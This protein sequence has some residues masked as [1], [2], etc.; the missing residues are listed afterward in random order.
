MSVL[1]LVSKLNVMKKLLTVL[2]MVTLIVNTA[3]SCKKGDIGPRGEQGQKGEKGDKG[4]KGDKG[5]TGNAN[6]ISRTFKT[7]SLTWKAS[8]VFGTNYV[9][10]SLAVPELTTDIINS[11]AVMVYGGF[12]WESP[13]SALPISFYETGKTNYFTFGI[14]AGTV[15]LRSHNST[16]TPPTAP[17]IDWRVVVIKGN[18]ATS[19]VDLTNYNE[20]RKFYHIE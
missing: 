16:N 3:P 13:W 14:K 12:F 20:V 11:G 9:E 10:A 18:A 4:A 5:S 1:I 19:E 7:G 8:V 6:V 2:M 17:S 15:T